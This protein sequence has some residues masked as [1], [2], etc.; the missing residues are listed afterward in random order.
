MMLH[1]EILMAA[2]A[3]IQPLGH[4][5]RS[6]RAWPT[7]LRTKSPALLI[8]EHHE[9]TVVESCKERAYGDRS[10]GRITQLSPRLELLLS[11]LKKT[12]TSPFHHA[13][14]EALQPSIALYHV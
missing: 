5:Y 11:L 9:P 7:V 4:H 3:M 10:I 2:N 13:A 12:T 1:P 14:A 6:L 8:E